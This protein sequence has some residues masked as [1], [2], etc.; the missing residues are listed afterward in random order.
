MADLFERLGFATRD[1]RH[2]TLTQFAELLL[3]QLRDGA[4]LDP[5][6][7][8]AEAMR[9]ARENPLVRLPQDFV[10]IGRVFMSLGGLIERYRPRLSLLQEIV[11]FLA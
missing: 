9:L 8:L 10:L 5:A 4:A 3:G 11:P 6:A 2:E 7:Q 1:G